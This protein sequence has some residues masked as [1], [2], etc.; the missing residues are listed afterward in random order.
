MESMAPAPCGGYT[1]QT[2][3][4]SVLVGAITIRFC[5]RRPGEE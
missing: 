3:L 4:A 2:A 1:V 5:G